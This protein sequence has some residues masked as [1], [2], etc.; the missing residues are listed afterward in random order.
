[1]LE[2]LDAGAERFATQRLGLELIASGPTCAP[3]DATNYLG[4]VGD[5][6]EDKA[7]REALEHLGSLADVALFANDRQIRQ[8]A[9]REETA[10]EPHYRVR[11][12]TLAQQ[13]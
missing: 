1:M 12:W 4:G 8:I 10:A 13:A 5:V 7:H 6:L 9:Y 2:A 3:S 11:L